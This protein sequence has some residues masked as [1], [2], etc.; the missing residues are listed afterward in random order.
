MA[1]GIIG[2]ANNSWGAGASDSYAYVSQMD[3]L[4][5]GSLKVSIAMAADVPWPN[6]L[7]TFTPFGYAAVANEPAITPITGPGLPLPMATFKTMAARPSSSS[8]R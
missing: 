1:I 5:G 7:A 2:I 3:P 8:C 4:R 6:A